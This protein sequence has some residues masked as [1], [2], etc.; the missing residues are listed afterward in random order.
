MEIFEINSNEAGKAN[1]LRMLA[2]DLGISLDDMIV[3][4]DNFNDMEMLQLAGKGIAVENSPPEV[5]AVAKE[6]C[7]SNK[8]GGVIRYLQEHKEDLIRD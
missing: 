6:I 7:G 1:G 2:E 3:F 4:G 5:K 8:D